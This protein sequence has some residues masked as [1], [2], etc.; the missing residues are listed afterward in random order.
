MD[1]TKFNKGEMYWYINKDVKKE[2]YLKD[3]ENQDFLDSRPVL[4]ISNY[5]DEYDSSVIIIPT[6]TSSHRC[7]IDIEIEDKGKIMTTKLMPMRQRYIP[8]KYLKTFIGRLNDDILEKV[9][10]AIDYH[11]GRSSKVPDY[12]IKDKLIHDKINKRIKEDKKE[13]NDIIDDIPIDEYDDE[14]ITPTSNDSS[15]MFICSDLVQSKN[16]LSHT[17]INYSDNFNIKEF[18]YSR[19]SA[20]KS[21]KKKYESLSSFKEKF[22]YLILDLKELAGRYSININQ[23]ILIK[24][25]CAMEFAVEQKILVSKFMSHSIKLGELSN[26]EKIVF[27]TFDDKDIVKCFRKGK[28]IVDF[29]RSQF[30]KEIFGIKKG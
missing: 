6:T 4:I 27:L 10:D 19:I 18:I 30:K 17:N 28:A 13:D 12:V 20:N 21:I 24:K 29:Y 11:Y 2:D 23:A 22:N 15:Y 25:L 8:V 1:V 9:Y 3:G 26:K 16:R 5:I 14:D 7:G